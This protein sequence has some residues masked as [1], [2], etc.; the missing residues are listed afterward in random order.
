MELKQFQH[1]GPLYSPNSTFFPKMSYIWKKR[2]SDFCISGSSLQFT[3]GRFF[4]HCLCN[5]MQQL[6][7]S[8]LW[9]EEWDHLSMAGAAGCSKILLPS[10][11]QAATCSEEVS[12]IMGHLQNLP[13]I[14]SQVITFCKCF[15]FF[16]RL[17]IA[18][19]GLWTVGLLDCFVTLTLMK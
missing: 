16:D 14:C 4:P 11:Q 12:A 9:N 13:W 6:F 8:L 1:P 18:A 17:F 10:H 7:S 3:L 15:Y 2:G 5:K 19:L